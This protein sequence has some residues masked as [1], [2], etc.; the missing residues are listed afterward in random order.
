MT[1]SA[2]IDLAVS[3]PEGLRSDQEYRVRIYVNDVMV[4]ER[5]LPATE[6]FR[7]E[8]VPLEQGDNDLRAALVSGGGEG[9]RSAP[10]AITRDDIAPEIH[11]ISPR[12]G[13]RV[14]TAEH[15]LTGRTEAGAD[16]SIGGRS[17]N[18][19]RATVDSS[20]RFEALLELAIGQN[21]LTLRSE[22]PA[23][24]VAQDRIVIVRAD[25]DA[26][27][28]LTIF[29]T[30]LDYSSLP[31][32]LQITAMVRDERGQPIDDALVTFGLSPPSLATTTHRATTSAGTV[33][34]T[35]VDIP[36]AASSKGIWLVT[37][38]VT[39]STG[40]ELRADESL[41]VE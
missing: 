26:S 21:P 9:Q 39:L 6:R 4:R 14:H 25:S 19:I 40:A 15:L 12:S 17:G 18:P 37:A 35:G 34:W 33:S 5:P 13:E 41:T 7:V 27:L 11:L 23:G 31:A 8:N 1:R 16:I 28:V 2:E 38:L 20:G 3:L 32:R 24:N 30:E 22:D 10:V 29:P 36:A